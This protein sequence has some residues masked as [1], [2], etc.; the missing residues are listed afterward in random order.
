[1]GVLG[2]T[3]LGSLA[4]ATHHHFLVVSEDH[5]GHLPPG[6]WRIPFQITAA[7][8]TPIDALGSVVG[9]RGLARRG[10]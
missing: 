8:A 10:A 4:F 6:G 3:M 2:V 7:L 9:I 5:V 1:M